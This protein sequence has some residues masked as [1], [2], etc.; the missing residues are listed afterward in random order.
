MTSTERPGTGSAPAGTVILA[1][2]VRAV[3]DALKP[4]PTPEGPVVV[5]VYGIGEPRARGLIRFP[6]V[7]EFVLKDLNSTLKTGVVLVHLNVAGVGIGPIAAVPLYVPK[8]TAE[9]LGVVQNFV[10]IAPTPIVPTGVTS[11]IAGATAAKDATEAI[12]VKRR[13]FFMILSVLLE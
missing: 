3:A 10:V 2:A 9:L 8:A 5:N 6:P 1:V 4:F 12:A 7:V 13:N 11:A